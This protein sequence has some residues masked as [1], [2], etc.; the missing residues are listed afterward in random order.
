MQLKRR[1]LSAASKYTSQRLPAVRGRVPPSK[2]G[3]EAQQSVGSATKP[4]DIR[5]TGFH[6]AALP[7]K[8]MR[9]RVLGGRYSASQTA[10]PSP[11]IRLLWGSPKPGRSPKGRRAGTGSI[12]PKTWRPICGE[13][14][15]SAEP[16]GS[17]TGSKVL[18]TM[19]D[20]GREQCS[21]RK[22]LHKGFLCLITNTSPKF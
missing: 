21:W 4:G 8:H 15:A 6:Q 2:A 11:I 12:H 13:M 3:A 1:A 7:Q 19:Q 5:D 16:L 18:S 9:L 22:P 17:G 14:L 20:R 10:A